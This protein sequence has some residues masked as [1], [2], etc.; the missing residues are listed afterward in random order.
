MVCEKCIIYL[1]FCNHWFESAA[2]IIM[3][4][5]LA[6]SDLHICCRD[7]KGTGQ[8]MF[9]PDPCMGMGME[10]EWG[11]LILQPLAQCTLTFRLILTL[12]KNR[13]NKSICTNPLQ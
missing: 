11:R 4:C 3:T 6:L 2:N 5:R 12:L 10:R 13:L 9:T 1:V 7:K 8:L